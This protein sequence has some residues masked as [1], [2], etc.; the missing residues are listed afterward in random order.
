M[1]KLLFA[2]LLACVITLSGC[3]SPTISEN[4]HD[5]SELEQCIDDMVDQIA[6]KKAV[7]IPATISIKK[8][9]T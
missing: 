1:K 2:L 7:K 3:S 9:R 5:L 4:G 8:F 6:E